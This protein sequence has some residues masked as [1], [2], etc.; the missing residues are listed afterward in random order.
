[1]NPNSLQFDQDTLQKIKQAQ[2][3]G[4]DNATVIK[5]ASAYQAAKTAQ[6]NPNPQPQQGGDLKSTLIDLLPL[7]GAVGGS[8]V[9][10]IGT[11]VGGAVGAGGGE[12]LKEFLK[13]ESPNPGEVIKQGAIGGIGGVAGKVLEPVVNVGGRLLAKGIPDVLDKAGTGAIAAQYNVPRTAARALKLPDTIEKLSK[14]GI[15]NINDIAPAAEKVT[16]ANGLVTKLTR[17]AVGSAGPV[18]TTGILD[19]AKE[20]AS[21][22]AITTGQDTKF[23][24]FINKG[25][26]KLFSANEKV[27]P[28][29]GKVGSKPTDFIQVT[30]EGV[31]SFA[32]KGAGDAYKGLNLSQAN[33]LDA[34][35]FIQQLEQEAAKINRI[36]QFQRTAQ[37]SALKDAYTQMASELKDRLF[38]G[39]GA[40]NAVAHGLMQPADFMEMAQIHPHLASEMMNAKTV[41]E[42]RSIAAPFVKGNQLAS[43]TEA[44]SQIG[45][46]GV[47]GAVKGVGKLF[48]NP[49]NLAAVPLSSDAVNSTVGQ[50]LKGAAAKFPEFSLPTIGSAEAATVGQV[51]VHGAAN[52]AGQVANAQPPMVGDLT[53]ATGTDGGTGAGNEQDQ[54]RQI[55]GSIMFSKAKNASDIAAAYNFLYGGTTKPTAQQQATSANAQ[56]GLRALNLLETTLQSDPNAPLKAHI[57]LVSRTTPY[58]TASREVADVLTRLRTGAALNESEIK[59]Y[60]GQLPQPFDS[61]STINYKLSLFRNLFNQLSQ[62]NGRPTL[63]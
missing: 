1:M 57:P 12:L 60:Q 41:G 22:P 35:D 56:S 53:S 18:D 3:A 38:T 19:Y 30:P 52:A 27:G 45:F 50:A 63:Q 16:G 54:L 6:A 32:Q 36:P 34:F 29:L 28:T 15:A 8:F 31:A 62:S 33:P 2:A 10:G 55:L 20:L 26:S 11:I 49:F 23:V 40:D 59:F 13:H 25:L 9:P 58:A 37:D 51:G 14:Y 17:K 5:K 43:E 7:L 4:F 39:A 61:P 24:S 48:Q 21:N 42:L 47:G 44:G 46:N